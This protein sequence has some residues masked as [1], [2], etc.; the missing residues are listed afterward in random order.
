MKTSAHGHGP[1]RQLRSR[2]SL[3]RSPFKQSVSAFHSVVSRIRRN[4]ARIDCLEMQ[5]FQ[6]MHGMY[7]FY[8]ETYTFLFEKSFVFV[9]GCAVLLSFLFL[10]SIYFWCRSYSRARF[11]IALAQSLSSFLLRKRCERSC[12][13][14][15][16][17]RIRTSFIIPTI[18]LF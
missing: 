8:F 12:P 18:L 11:F 5:R 15:S 13:H 4:T 17:Y 9:V 14:K 7:D 6:K 3:R 16:F 1:Q 10:S 2:V